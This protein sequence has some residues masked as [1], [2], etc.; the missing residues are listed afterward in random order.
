MRD[1]GALDLR[2]DV[3]GRRIV[4]GFAVIHRFVRDGF[5]S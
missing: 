5:T 4:D 3:P 1:W 2:S